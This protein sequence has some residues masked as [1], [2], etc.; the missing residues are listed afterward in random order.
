MN[1]DIMADA[2]LFDIE[3]PPPVS[4]A[5]RF[6]VAPFSI[7][8]RRQGEWQDRKRR[9]LALGIQSEVGRTDRLL[10]NA[11]NEGWGTGF[12]SEQ[13][14]AQGV[15]SIFDP[16]LCEL[17]YRWFSAV[18]DRVLDPFA[19]GSVRG[20]VASTL[21][22]WYT[23]IDLRSEQVTANESQVALCSDI[24][25]RWIQGDSAR[26]HEHL[27]PADEFDL[28]FS[29]PPY[30]DLEVYSDNP[31]DLSTMPYE[32]FREAHA[33]VISAAT[34]RLRQDRFAVWVISD[35]R[36]KRGNYRGLVGHTVEAFQ[37]AGLDLYNDAVVL[38]PVG[39]VRLR[40]GNLFTRTRKLSRLHQHVLVFAKGNAKKAA[41]RLGEA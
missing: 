6:G 40:A 32:Q 30:A 39:T 26:L 25:P 35:I 4:L 24:T 29:C 14:I 19:G 7:L 21:A 17:A 13:M 34:A 27:D 23:G 5:D 28:L 9:W 31:R 20:V 18:G 12:V 15:T 38:D 11:S 22:R 36:D 41:R 2:Q 37:A 16:V 8:D 1:G 33:T 10:S 3:E